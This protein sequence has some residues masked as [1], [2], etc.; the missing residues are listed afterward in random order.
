[1]TQQTRFAFDGA[2]NASQFITA[3]ETAFTAV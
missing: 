2:G 1:M 3:V